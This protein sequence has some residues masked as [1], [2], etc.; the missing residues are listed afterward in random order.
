[1]SDDDIQESGFGWAFAVGAGL[2]L[3]VFGAIAAALLGFVR[4]P[5]F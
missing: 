1:M 2:I 4:V 3:L 5:W